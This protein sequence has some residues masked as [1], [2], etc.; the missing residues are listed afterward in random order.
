MSSRTIAIDF[1]GV[2][3]SYTSPFSFEALDS[4][5]PGAAEFI[6]WLL[7]NS[8]TPIIYSTR[9]EHPSGFDQITSWLESEGFPP[10]LEITAVKPKAL[11]YIDDRAF[12]FE[13][14]FSAIC[15]FISS[16]AHFRTWNKPRKEPS[17]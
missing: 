4:P 1:D 6:R 11:L 12:R 3:H 7:D 8:Y 13:G 5:T 9:A 10:G 16:N 17:R 15:D 2:L 14:D